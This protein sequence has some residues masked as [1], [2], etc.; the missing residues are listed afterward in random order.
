[1]IPQYILNVKM[2]V[3]GIR[4]TQWRKD[5]LPPPGVLCM[6]TLGAA[7]SGH[8]RGWRHG[9]LDYSEPQGLLLSL[10]DTELRDVPLSHRREGLLDGS[11]QWFMLLYRVTVA[12][13]LRRVPIACFLKLEIRATTVTSTAM[14]RQRRQVRPGK[15]WGSGSV[16]GDPSVWYKYNKAINVLIY[17]ALDKPHIPPKRSM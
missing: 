2:T 11:V 10:E 3:S 8:F 7:F 9:G 12:P 4:S 14:L 1:M 15:M 16:P 5:F 17:I 13:V 6:L